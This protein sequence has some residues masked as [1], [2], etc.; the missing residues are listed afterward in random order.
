[1]TRLCFIAENKRSVRAQPKAFQLRS[2]IFPRKVGE[3]CIVTA[4]PACTAVQ[5][6]R[7]S[8]SLCLQLL[9]CWNFSLTIITTIGCTSAVFEHLKIVQESSHNFG[10]LA[11]KL[12]TF[13]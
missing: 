12:N 10:I 5:H 2:R 3:L 6:V 4:M 1:M 7:V 9:W 8:L 11:M 13:F